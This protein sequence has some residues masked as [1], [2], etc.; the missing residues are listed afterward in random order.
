MEQLFIE[1]QSYIHTEQ[2]ERA[3]R[4]LMEIIMDHPNCVEALND[5]AV[6]EILEQK[7]QSGLELLNEVLLIDPKNDDALNNISYV[8]SRLNQ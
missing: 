5:L 7:Y 8:K 6:V 4:L 2:Y 3:R 1:A